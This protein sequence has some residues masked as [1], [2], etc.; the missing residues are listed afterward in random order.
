MCMIRES[1]MLLL[2]NNSSRVKESICGLTKGKEIDGNA[3]L[4]GDSLTFLDCS[5]LFVANPV[6]PHERRLLDN[7]VLLSCALVVIIRECCQAFSVPRG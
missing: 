6:I 4:Q 7:D 3:T 1:W 5:F 2:G